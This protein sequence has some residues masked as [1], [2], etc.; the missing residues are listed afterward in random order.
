MEGHFYFCLHEEL[1]L[2]KLKLLKYFK[3]GPP[4]GNLKIIFYFHAGQFKNESSQ[5]MG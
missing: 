3:E 5:G 4:L 1:C 2:E